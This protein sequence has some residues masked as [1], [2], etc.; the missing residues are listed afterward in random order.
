MQFQS[1]VEC[2]LWKWDHVRQ[3][4]WDVSGYPGHSM[5]HKC[6]CEPEP[7]WMCVETGSVVYVHRMW[8]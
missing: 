1:A 6:W 5:T 8:H 4:P 7:V 3:W 2:L